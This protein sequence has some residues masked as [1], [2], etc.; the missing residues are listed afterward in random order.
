MLLLGLTGE[1]IPEILEGEGTLR[2]E[3]QGDPKAP[4]GDHEYAGYM[5]P[6]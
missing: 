6:Q 5:V 3:R 1:A 4:P 2:G